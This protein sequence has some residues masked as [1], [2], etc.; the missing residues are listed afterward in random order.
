M[1]LD[2]EGTELEQML[3]KATGQIRWRRPKGCNDSERVL[4]QLWERVTGERSWH[5]VQTLLED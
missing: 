5:P 3:W 4:E 2:L 1:P